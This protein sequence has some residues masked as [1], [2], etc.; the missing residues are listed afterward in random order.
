M[1]L[2][3]IAGALSIER[4]GFTQWEMVDYFGNIVEFKTEALYHHKLPGPLFSPQVLSMRCVHI[5]S[6]TQDVELTEEMA[7]VPVAFT[8]SDTRPFEL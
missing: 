6:L 4:S 3:G 2:G 7:P 1:S 5:L 8:A